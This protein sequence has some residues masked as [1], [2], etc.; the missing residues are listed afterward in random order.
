[1]FDTY[2]TGEYMVSLGGRTKRFKGDTF[3]LAPHVLMEVG[4]AQKRLESMSAKVPLD[5]PWKARHAAKWDAQTLETWLVR[6]LRF[7][8]SRAFW[9]TIAAAIFSAEATEMSLLHFLFYCHSGGMLDRLMGTAGGA[10]EK[11]L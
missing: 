5:A 10:Q 11:A 8:R 3:G 4:I 9:R 1:M 7:D 2:D 6:N